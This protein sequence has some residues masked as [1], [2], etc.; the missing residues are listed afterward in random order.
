MAISKAPKPRGYTFP[1]ALLFFKATERTFATEDL[2][3]VISEGLTKR[4]KI[5]PV[6]ASSPRLLTF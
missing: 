4:H 1:T 2:R 5:F 3:K 6:L